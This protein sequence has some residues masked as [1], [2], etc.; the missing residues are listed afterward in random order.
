MAH[1]VIPSGRQRGEMWN[2]GYRRT[3]LRIR[4]RDKKRKVRVRKEDQD[5]EEEVC[6][7]SP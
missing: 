1:C 2:D 7:S 5:E 3:G 4:K 6:E